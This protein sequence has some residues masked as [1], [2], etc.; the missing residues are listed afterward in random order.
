M[1]RYAPCLLLLLLAVALPPAQAA[2]RCLGTAGATPAYSVDI[3]PQ[4]GVL[5]TFRSWAQLLQR[6]GQESGL[7]FHLH[8]SDNFPDFEHALLSGVP[9]FI[10]MNPYHEVMGRHAAGYIPL[11]RDGAYEL[12]G[13]LVVRRDSPIGDP[14]E[15]DG[16]TIAF[17]APNA[18]AA[19]LLTRSYLG[20]LG[21][22]F[23][24]Q[25]VGS[26]SNAYRAAV[27]GN[28][29]A[30]GGANTTFDR[31]SAALRQDLRILYETPPSMPHPL[32]AHPRVPHAA[33]EAVISAMLRMA[34]EP[35]AQPLLDAVQIPQPVRA[36]YRRDYG[37][38]EA[39][40]LERLVN[41]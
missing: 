37:P 29:A 28:V 2:E 5:D 1:S 21:V 9:D 31:E 18:Y 25:Y 20:K 8:I 26:H 13:I 17:P 7:C 36:D 3:V 14:H 35:S 10:Y 15:L 16:S 24:P 34:Q 40:G 22:H 32:A 27:I 23:T 12:K 4:R 41:H 38:I 11:I 19:S 30:A 39:L 33:R 6:L